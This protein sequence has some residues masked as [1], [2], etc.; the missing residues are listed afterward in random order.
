MV[1]HFVPGSAKLLRNFTIY[2]ALYVIEPPNN[3]RT[4]MTTPKEQYPE[5][6]S[7]LKH[8]AYRKYGAIR[9]T[10]NGGTHDADYTVDRGKMLFWFNTKDKS[11]HMILGC[12][13]TNEV[14]AS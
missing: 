11:S 3:Q 5:L 14:I 7:K 12:I 4:H 10:R 9:P 6:A 2:R 1:L 13:E 8:Y